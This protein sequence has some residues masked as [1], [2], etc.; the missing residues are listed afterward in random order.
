MLPR[1]WQANLVSMLPTVVSIRSA[2]RAKHARGEAA[3]P[4][5]VPVGQA[6]AGGAVRGAVLE[7]KSRVPFL[8]KAGQ[9]LCVFRFARLAYGPPRV[10]EGYTEGVSLPRLQHD[11][12]G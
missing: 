9:P 1:L 7:S 12:I 4:D 8:A 5:E 11:D 6:F 3:M 2:R 10:I